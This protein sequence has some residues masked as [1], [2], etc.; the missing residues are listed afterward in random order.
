MR[1]DIAQKEFLGYPCNLDYNYSEVE[2]SLRY[3]FNNVGTP[4]EDSLYR[5]HTKDLELKV[6]DFFQQLWGF[7]KED[8]EVS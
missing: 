1:C 2:R 7:D 4:Y 3:H 8:V 6:L 5:V